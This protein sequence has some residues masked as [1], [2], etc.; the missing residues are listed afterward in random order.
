MGFVL[1]TVCV[2]A[3][4]IGSQFNYN[5]FLFLINVLFRVFVSEDNI[6]YYLINKNQLIAKT[7]ERLNRFG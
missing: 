7:Q 6:V 4:A 3:G 1:L 5:I 2:T